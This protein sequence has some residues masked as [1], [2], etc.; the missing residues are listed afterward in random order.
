M[1]L[2][3]TNPNKQTLIDQ[4]KQSI[5]QQQQIQNQASDI[6]ATKSAELDTLTQNLQALRAEKDASR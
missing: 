3:D 5:G 4:S 2:P 1:A 6:V